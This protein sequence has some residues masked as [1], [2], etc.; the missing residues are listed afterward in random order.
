MI[1][2]AH[3][4]TRLPDDI[5]GELTRIAD[6][7]FARLGGAPLVEAFWRPHFQPLRPLVRGD[8]AGAP[9]RAS[10]AS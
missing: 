10:H 7:H 4:P 5:E 3:F 8:R 9:A 6:E 1:S 2:P